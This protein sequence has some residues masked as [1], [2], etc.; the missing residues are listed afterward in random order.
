MIRSYEEDFI[1]V[2][3]QDPRVQNQ[4]SWNSYVDFKIF[5]HTNSKAFTA[6]TS[7]VR[8]RYS[9]FVWLKKKMQKN[10]GLVQVPD[11]PSKS[12]F[13]F[14]NED[15]LEKRRKGLQSF[16]DKVLHMTVCLSDSQ[17]H[18]FLQTQLPIGHIQDCVQGHTPYTV[19]DAI[20]TYASSNQGWAQEEDVIP[21]RTPTPVPYESMESPAPHLPTLP[22]EVLSNPVLLTSSD[23]EGIHTEE[24]ISDLYDTDTGE[25]QCTSPS[26]IALQED[27]CLEFH[28]PVE[29]TSVGDH[30][31]DCRWQTS[32]EVHCLEGAEEEC[33]VIVEK[34][35][36]GEHS[37]ERIPHTHS[38]CEPICHEV[39]CPGE[40]LETAV[41]EQ[42]SHVTLTQVDDTLQD[43]SSGEDTHEPG[44]QDDG[45]E[46]LHETDS[47]TETHHEEDH[48]VETALEAQTGQEAT[49]EKNIVE[50]DDDEADCD[51]EIDLH[52][53][54]D[55]DRQS[56]RKTSSEE[57]SVGDMMIGDANHVELSLV[58]N[59]FQETEREDEH[60]STDST[61]VALRN[62][63]ARE[64]ATDDPSQQDSS[65]EANSVP[66]EI[67]CVKAREEEEISYMTNSYLAQT[68]E[69][70]PLGMVDV[71]EE[72]HTLEV[73]EK[74][75]LES[76]DD[77]STEEVILLTTEP[78][79]E[80]T[81]KSHEREVYDSAADANLTVNQ[82]KELEL[83]LHT[84]SD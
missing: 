13:S 55:L 49:Q 80:V 6:K 37:E 67:V 57:S 81:L 68:L 47:H 32:V 75:H 14:I 5:L 61:D 39:E 16:L 51:E 84:H 33:L 21:E 20:L 83:T 1:A 23:P 77:H 15:F 18:L 58:T 7:C 63:D 22:S 19:T 56:Q 43:T 2:R 34:V 9:E 42:A 30:Q 54:M 29:T 17:L 27:S 8:R 41:G 38:T 82:D 12:Y 36:K 52:R 59:G 46:H 69:Q 44:Q 64:K 74:N 40:T 4:G 45:E 71:V 73:Q 50:V 62:T 10:C 72:T 48:H 53:E 25:L 65:D 70:L 79:S 76:S 66:D 26:L 60:H 24:S 31:V 35:L 11:L 3:V 28:C 78:D